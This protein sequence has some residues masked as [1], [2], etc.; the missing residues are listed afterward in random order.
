MQY[1]SSSSA[2]TLKLQYTQFLKMIK[3][4]D[5]C[6]SMHEH[7]CCNT[8]SITFVTTPIWIRLSI[9]LL[10][11][12]VLIP[13]IQDYKPPVPLINPTPYGI[14]CLVWHMNLN[15]STIF[16][17]IEPLQYISCIFSLMH[18]H[19]FFC[20]LQTPILESMMRS[21]SFSSFSYTWV[22]FHLITS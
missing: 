3:P 20:H 6:I 15:D 18:L 22:H 10:F 16:I 17:T 19:S 9:H 14:S 2:H 1:S 12:V 11:L 5:W 8:L 4:W 7:I 13:S 21:P